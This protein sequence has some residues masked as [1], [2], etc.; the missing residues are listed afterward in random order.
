VKSVSDRLGVAATSI[1]A[2]IDGF[3]QKLRAA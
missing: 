3:V 1:R 2:Q